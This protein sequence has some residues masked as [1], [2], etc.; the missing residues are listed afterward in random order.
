[1]GDNFRTMTRTSQRSSV[2]ERCLHKA[3][4]AGPIPAA[5]TREIAYRSASR[6]EVRNFR[7]LQTLLLKSCTNRTE[8][9]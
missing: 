6:R 4:V 2:V 1:M 7:A 5:G 8:K 3:H 9:T